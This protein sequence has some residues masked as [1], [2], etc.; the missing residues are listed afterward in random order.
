MIF[1]AY[2]KYANIC[3]KKKMKQQQIFFLFRIMGIENKF[4]YLNKVKF[5]YFQIVY[6]QLQQ[7]ITIPPLCITAKP[8]VP[9]MKVP[10]IMLEVF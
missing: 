1:K 4:C 10:Q 3:I 9:S 8:E 6:F 7:V 5:G 2:R